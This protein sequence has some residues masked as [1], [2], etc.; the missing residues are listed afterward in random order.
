MLFAINTSSLAA[1]S[2]TLQFL[3]KT[4]LFLPQGKVRIMPCTMLFAIPDGLFHSIMYFPNNVGIRNSILLMRE[5]RVQ[6]VKVI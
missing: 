1:L 6:D 2:Y 5:L 3:E 4:N